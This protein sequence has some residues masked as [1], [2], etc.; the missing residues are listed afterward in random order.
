MFLLVRMV[1][2]LAVVLALLPSG[3]AKPDTTR[4]GLLA[5]CGEAG[6]RMLHDF[7]REERRQAR[8]SATTATTAPPR[9]TANPSQS[10]LTAADLAPAWRGPRGELHRKHGA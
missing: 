8:S 5:A 2:W 6:V 1:F 4:P 7:M 10:T 3:G 9:R